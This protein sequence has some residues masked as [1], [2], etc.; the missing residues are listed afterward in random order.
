M[1]KKLVFFA[2]ITL[3][4]L[5]YALRQALYVAP[6]EE[7]M[8]DIQRI[9]YY[10]VPSAFAAFVCFFANLAASL[11]YLK[12]R[13]PA[14]DAFAVA[15]AEVGVVF[16]SVVLVTGPL[17]AKPVWGIW[18]TWD[19]RLTSTLL[20]WLIYVSYLLLRRFSTGGQAPVLAAVLAVF[21][22]LDVIFVYMS[23]RW[24][25]TQHPQPVI[26][27]GEGSGL[28]PAMAYALVANIL[29]F[30]AFAALVVWIRY[31]LERT[32]QLLDEEHALAATQ[33]GG[34]A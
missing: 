33:R 4:L 20:L 24:F 34:G 12:N 31:R 5:W 22:S 19:A 17:W 18:W 26:A 2:L 3:V 7:T 10:H 14:V 21:G 1:N 6:T 32:R 11:V 8:G 23:I 25:R 27:G 16:C 13:K 30:L 9:F 28:H 15:T 29:A